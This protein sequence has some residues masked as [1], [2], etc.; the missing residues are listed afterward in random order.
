MQV[1]ELRVSEIIVGDRQRKDFGD[2]EGLKFSIEHHG[3]LQPIVVEMREDGKYQLIAG[4]R[5]LKAHQELQRETIQ[6]VLR[7]D[8]DE[9][10]KKELEFEENAQRKNLTIWEEVEAIAEIHRLKKERYNKGLPGRYGRGGWSQ[11]DTALQLDVSEGKVSQDLLLAEAIKKFPKLK[12]AKTRKDAL[13]ML[14]HID[15]TR[16]EDSNVIKRMRDCFVNLSVQEGAGK[17][18]AGSVDLI[19]AECAVYDPKEIVNTIISRLSI[20]GHAFLFVPLEQFVELNKY[21]AEEAHLQT[22]GRP[23]IW[24]IRGEDTFQ[25]YI[26]C[27]R[28]MASPPRY[29]TEHTSHKRD[30]NAEH[31][32]GKPYSLYNHL[33]D[34]SSLRGG[35]VFAPCV[36]DTAVVK[37]AIDLNRSILA[38]CP[39]KTVYEQCML[40]LVKQTNSE[41]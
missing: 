18:D 39:N 14:R 41:V 7:S 29:V 28:G 9:L 31:S 26:W 38:V 17:V 16:D 13:Y 27:S 21:L 23:Y 4:G 33:I 22:R 37:A 6:A 25:T 11:R 10:A 35:F 34:N 19:I 24:H 12:E 3:L 2:M 1:L 8:L 32:L 20:T 5:R 36:F 40:N 30:P 15:I